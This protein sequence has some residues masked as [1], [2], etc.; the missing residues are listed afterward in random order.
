METTRARLRDFAGTSWAAA[1][2]ASGRPL[3]PIPVLAPVQLSS[4][5][6]GMCRAV[7]WRSRARQAG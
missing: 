4:P 3:H 5:L 7:L 6:A 2:G 1:L